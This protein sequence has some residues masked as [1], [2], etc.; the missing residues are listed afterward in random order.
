MQIKI[1]PHKFSSNRAEEYVRNYVNPL[2]SLHLE[3]SERRIVASQLNV[4][5]TT[6]GFTRLL[7]PLLRERLY[8]QFVYLTRLVYDLWRERALPGGHQ[9]VDY[10]SSNLFK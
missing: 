9:E 7:L 10:G 2:F 5:N 4:A 1:V 3:V 6:T 8:E